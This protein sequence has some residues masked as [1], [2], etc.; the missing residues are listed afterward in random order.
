MNI[1][2]AQL[3][4]SLVGGPSSESQFS[5]ALHFAFLFDVRGP[6][7]GNLAVTGIR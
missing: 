4:V 5:A 7:L 2:G 6:A 3:K 1:N